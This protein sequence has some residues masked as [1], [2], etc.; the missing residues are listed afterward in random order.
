MENR[1]GKYK[2]ELQRKEKIISELEAQLEAQRI[3]N[4]NRTEVE[5]ISF[6][7]MLF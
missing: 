1:L 4:K 2:D 6:W 3:S 7:S 5:T